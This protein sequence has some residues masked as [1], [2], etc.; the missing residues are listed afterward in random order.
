MKRRIRRSKAITLVLIVVILL[1]AGALIFVLTRKSVDDVTVVTKVSRHMELPSDTPVVAE[2]VDTEKLQS[3]LKKI[4]LK[5]DYILLYDKKQ[6]VIVY[7]PST[8]KI[9]AVQPILYGKQPN[10]NIEYTVAV[11]N[12]SGNDDLLKSFIRKLYTQYPNLQLVVKDVAPRSF[13]NTIV[14]TKDDSSQIAHE[15]ADGLGIKEGITP[16]GID[17]SVADIV[18]IVGEDYKT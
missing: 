12:G 6:Q 8:D 9:I 4:A 13:P 17:A 7:R 16:N 2:V 18:F 5:G 11:Y 3:S 1:L 15:I 10:A 14:F